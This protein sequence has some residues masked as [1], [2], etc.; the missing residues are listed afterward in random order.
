MQIG[1]YF[2]VKS[3]F[4][5]MFC[6][7][8]TTQSATSRLDINVT[9]KVLEEHVRDEMKWDRCILKKCEPY[10]VVWGVKSP[11]FPSPWSFFSLIF[12][13]PSL[14]TLPFLIC[15]HPLTKFKNDLCLLWSGL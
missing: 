12:T 8:Q 5:H 13:R 4:S 6:R 2:S 7:L 15:G 1:L 11:I 10:L 14:L 3:A 9:G